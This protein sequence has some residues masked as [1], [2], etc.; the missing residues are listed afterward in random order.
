MMGVSRKGNHFHKCCAAPNMNSSDSCQFFIQFSRRLR[1]SSLL[2]VYEALHGWRE[3][4]LQLKW[5]LIKKK[6]Q[7][8]NIHSFQMHGYG[9]YGGRP[10][11]ND[12]LPPYPPE[13]PYMDPRVAPMDGYTLTSLDTSN[14]S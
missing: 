13:P 10:L 14:E 11:P 9:D 2:S 6:R 5:H 1:D 7:T 3:D 4:S 12:L 8:N